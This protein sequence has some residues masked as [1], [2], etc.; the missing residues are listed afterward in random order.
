MD[1]KASAAKCAF[2]TQEDFNKVVEQCMNI[3]A[4]REG[5]NCEVNVDSYFPFGTLSYIHQLNLKVQRLVSLGNIIRKQG[6]ILPGNLKDI[7]ESLFD[8][9]NYGIRFGVKLLDNSIIY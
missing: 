4:S 9:L 3:L 8:M 6:E 5:Y 1:T 2:L 7:R